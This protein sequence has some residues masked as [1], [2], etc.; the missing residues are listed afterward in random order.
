MSRVSNDIV[1]DKL[2]RPVMPELDSLRGVAILLVL[3]FHGFDFPN[4]H[5]PRFAHAFISLTLIGWTGVNL[6]FVLSG[7]LITGILLG[8]KAKPGYYSRFYARRALRILPAYYT[9]LFLLWALSRCGWLWHRP[10]GWPFLTLSFFYLA[11]LVPLFGVKSQYTVLWSLAVEEHFYILW[12]TLVRVLSPRR[13]TLCCALIIAACPM[14]RGL[15]YV[16]GYKYAAQYTWLVADGLACGSLLAVLGRSLLANRAPMRRFSIL[17]IA[18][19]ASLL[20]LGAPLGI[21]HSWTLSGAALRLSAVNVFYTGVL[22][23]ALLVGTSRVRWTLHRPILQFFGKISYGLYLIHILV[24]DVV[25]WQISRIWPGKIAAIP[26]RFDL[27]FLRFLVGIGIA[28]G[29]AYLSRIYFEEYFLRLKDRWVIAQ[30]PAYTAE[31]AMQAGQPNRPA[32]DIAFTATVPPPSQPH[33]LHPG[34]APQFLDE[35]H[36]ESFRK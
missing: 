27:V 3:F 36:G 21:W 15:S 11:N 10:V 17:C 33:S 8:S 31:K 32:D 5:F 4:T 20:V 2:I 22:G 19:S 14:L 6:F 23:A 13:I 34:T 16:L 29:V 24:F 12:P 18:I 9:V 7:F 26:G 25:D 1:P 35:R 30:G 28:I